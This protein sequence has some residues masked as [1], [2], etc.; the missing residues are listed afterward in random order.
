MPED[1]Q[2]VLARL[3]IQEIEEDEKWLASTAAN[4]KQFEGL[5]CDVLAADDRCDC[6]PLD[7]HRM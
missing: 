5:V 6:E 7:G 3:L 1:R 2:E 4:A